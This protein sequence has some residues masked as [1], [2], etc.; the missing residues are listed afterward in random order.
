MRRSLRGAPKAAGIRMI[1]IHGRT[2]CQFYTG[3]ADWAAI[4]AVKRAVGIPVIAN[5][6]IIDAVTAAR[7][8]AACRGRT[9]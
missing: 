4:A 7:G 9:A 8:A 5:G 1:T 2:R 3:S 6:D